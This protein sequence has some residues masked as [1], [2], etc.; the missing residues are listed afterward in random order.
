MAQK[1]GTN[2]NGSPVASGI[3]LYRISIKSLEGNETF[4]KT[5][6]LIMLK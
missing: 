4:V 3:Y 6:K 5:A 1:S 2:E